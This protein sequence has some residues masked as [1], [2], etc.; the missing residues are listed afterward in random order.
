[1][2]ISY[3]A[4]MAI[5]VIFYI[6]F[7]NVCLC[8]FLLSLQGCATEPVIGLI[9]LHVADGRTAKNLDRR[10]TTHFFSLTENGQPQNVQEFHSGR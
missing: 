10:E 1:M 4:H 8:Y 9:M 5:K 6:V 2:A 3:L 7:K